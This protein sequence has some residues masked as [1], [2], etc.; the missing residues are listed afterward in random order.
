M[1]EKMPWKY[2]ILL[3]GLI[4]L[5][6]FLLSLVSYGLFTVGYGL[7]TLITAPS[8][9][10]EAISQAPMVTFTELQQQLVERGHDI[11]VDGKICKGWN[12]PEHSETLTAW[13]KEICDDYY[14]KTVAR[15][16]KVK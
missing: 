16:E 12:C 14:R 10:Q 5:G 13:S 8:L 2:R 7:Y 3:I 6:L 1:T 4:L 11:K 15:M 9:P